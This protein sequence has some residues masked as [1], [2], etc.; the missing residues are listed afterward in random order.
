MFVILRASK[1]TNES[2]SIFLLKTSKQLR[3]NYMAAQATSQVITLVE[4]VTGSKTVIGEGSNQGDIIQLQSYLTAPTNTGLIQKAWGYQ[5]ADIFN[6]NFELPGN[7]KVGID[8]NTGNLKAFG[9]MLVEPDWDVRAK[10]IAIDTNQ[11]IVGAAIDYAAAAA[12]QASLGLAGGTVNAI[13]TTAKL[14]LDLANIA[15]NASLDIE[16]YNNDLADIDNFFNDQNNQDWGSVNI[17]DTRT[18]VE[19][20]DFQPGVDIITLP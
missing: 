17:L 13:A 9:Q 20:R 12:D 7:G 14:A 2:T 16:E 11:A 10:R 3:R 5:S 15:A 19:I 1:K 8:F 6:V 4:P 18:V